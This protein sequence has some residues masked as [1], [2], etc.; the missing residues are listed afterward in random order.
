M[1]PRTVVYAAA[2]AA[3]IAMAGCATMN[4]FPIGADGKTYLDCRATK[5]CQVEL[6]HGWWRTEF[7]DEILVNVPP[8][9]KATITWT[10]KGSD[11][12]TFAQDGG[13]YLKDPAL[14]PVFDCK[15]DATR[16]HVYACTNAKDLRP[17]GRY[18]YGIRTKG[19]FSGP[20]IDP[21]IKNGAS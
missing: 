20:D 12:T 2:S 9:G 6:P 21:V 18:P 4:Q 11:G 5:D 10:I 3:V 1:K 15:P 19:F 13:I 7:P 14:Q 8:G 16:K 17:D